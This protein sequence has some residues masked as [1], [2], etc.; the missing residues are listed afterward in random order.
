MELADLVVDLG[1]ALTVVADQREANPRQAREDL[2]DLRFFVG[3]LVEQRLARIVVRDALGDQHA[4][5]KS[6]VPQEGFDREVQL[7]R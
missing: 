4:R 6:V 2:L 5:R 3:H 1:V 7:P